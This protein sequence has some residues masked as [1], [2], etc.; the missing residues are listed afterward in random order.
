MIAIKVWIYSHL[1]PQ[2]QVTTLENL[3]TINNRGL[4]KA[5]H[6]S[7][8]PL[9]VGKTSCFSA[10]EHFL[11]PFLYMTSYKLTP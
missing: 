8:A 3:K 4:A 5:E 1:C 11:L 2:T 6:F 7:T 9:S 10:G